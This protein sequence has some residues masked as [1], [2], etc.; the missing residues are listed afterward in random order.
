VAAR[1]PLSFRFERKFRVASDFCCREAESGDHR[2]SNAPTSTARTSGGSALGQNSRSK[3]VEG[4]DFTWEESGRGVL[5]GGCAYVPKSE[6]PTYSIVFFFSLPIWRYA[7][8][9]LE[10]TYLLLM[11]AP[12][13]NFDS[14]LS[15]FAASSGIL[16]RLSADKVFLHDP[17]FALRAYP[18][19][20]SPD[21]YTSH[22]WPTHCM[23]VFIRRRGARLMGLPLA[24][25]NEALGKQE[26]ASSLVL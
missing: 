10:G 3:L 22:V 11:C 4:F 20:H 16:A 13:F 5:V 23:R 24:R 18:A 9:V 17:R 7:L 26:H 19:H 2:D 21:R 6:I 8:R 14:R 25:P 15:C 12:Y 1:P